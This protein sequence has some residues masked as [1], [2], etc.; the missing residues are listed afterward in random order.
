[1][2]D[3]VELV[4]S[5]E[6]IEDACGQFWKIGS[7]RAEPKK[8]SSLAIALLMHCALAAAIFAAGK[9]QPPIRHDW[10]EVQ[11]VA[12]LGGSG[13]QGPDAPAA[14]TETGDNTPKAAAQQT[15]PSN[16][17]A[18]PPETLKKDEVR[19][20][21]VQHVIEKKKVTLAV[22]SKKPTAE[23]KTAS[24]NTRL[25]KENP[26]ENPSDVGITGASGNSNP[27]GE[28]GLG[29]G[30]SPGAGQGTPGGLTGNGGNAGGG[31]MGEVA[32]GSPNGPRFLHKVLPSYPDFARRQEMQGTVLLRITIDEEGR[33]VGVDILK[34]AGFGFD[35]A[36]VKAIRESTFIPAKRDGRSCV[37]KAL[38]PIRFEL[39][40]PGR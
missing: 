23:L 1:M 9:P 11:L 20:K 13:R 18:L 14:L 32:F 3:V 40:S 24:E 26:A 25:S 39:K 33:V 34:K 21:P 30:T 31:G 4:V 5:T 37:C 19:K 6:A 29:S 36:A 22:P 15:G 10:I 8:C 38:L 27:A 2:E 17:A 28:Q 16:H 35:E 12:S 7:P